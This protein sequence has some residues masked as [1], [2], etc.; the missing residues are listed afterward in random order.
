VQ[1]VAALSALD[2]PRFPPVTAEELPHLA[3]E[4]SV[5]SPLRPV[6]DPEEIVIGRDGLFLLAGERTGLLLPQVPVERGWHREAFLRAICLKAGL[7]EDAWRWPDA[8]LFRFEAEVFGA[9]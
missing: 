9:S 1:R 5:L 2:D 6:A 7:P 8:R 3:Y 4:I